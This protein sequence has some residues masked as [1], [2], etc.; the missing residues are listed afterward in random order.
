MEK[1]I[2][3]LAALL[4]VYLFANLSTITITYASTIAILLICALC[5]SLCLAISLMT[6]GV[7]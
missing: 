1:F 7:K 2:F 3:I 4:P 5:V 6:R